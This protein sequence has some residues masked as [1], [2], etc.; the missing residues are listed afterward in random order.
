MPLRCSLWWGRA[1]AGLGA[2]TR[3][4][5]SRELGRDQIDAV[6]RDT[7]QKSRSGKLW[8][9]QG[10]FKESKP[11]MYAYPAHRPASGFVSRRTTRTNTSGKTVLR[12]RDLVQTV[13]DIS[14]YRSA[15]NAQSDLSID[16]QGTA[17]V[18]TDGAVCSGS[19]EQWAP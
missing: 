5:R 3:S 15:K 2:C 11:A 13:S 19:I 17:F 9:S 7:G 8:R 18:E 16:F 4:I 14:R 12:S 6:K 1:G 10:L